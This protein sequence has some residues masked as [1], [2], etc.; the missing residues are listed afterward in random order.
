M[1]QWHTAKKLQGSNADALQELSEGTVKMEK[2]IYSTNINNATLYSF[3]PSLTGSCF[4]R[5]PIHISS[6]SIISHSQW[7]IPVDGEHYL[8]AKERPIRGE[9]APPTIVKISTTLFLVEPPAHLRDKAL[10]KAEAPRPISC[11]CYLARAR[12]RMKRSIS[13]PIL[14]QSYEGVFGTSII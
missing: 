10:G 9:I 7:S 4:T 14:H 12:I 2:Q 3:S 8:S 5:N 6:H 13:L 11:S 1:C